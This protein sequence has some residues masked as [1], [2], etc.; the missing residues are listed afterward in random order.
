[1]VLKENKWKKYTG[2]AL[3]VGGVSITGV[4]EF[5]TDIDYVSLGQ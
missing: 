4:N 3:I 2:L 5:V 1:M